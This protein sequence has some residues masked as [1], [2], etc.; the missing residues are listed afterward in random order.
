MVLMSFRARGNSIGRHDWGWLGGPYS[1]RRGGGLF[2]GTVLK[3]S[4]RHGPALFK[5]DN[6]WVFVSPRGFMRYSWSATGVGA[7]PFY[8]VDMALS[9]GVHGAL[10][11]KGALGAGSAV[12]RG[13]CV[14]PLGASA[15]R[16]GD[17]A[18]FHGEANHVVGGAGYCRWTC[19]PAL[20]VL[21]WSGLFGCRE[22]ARGCSAVRAA[23]L[24]I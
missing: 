17:G 23:M 9:A 24:V 5:P 8:C 2:F 12:L 14:I 3:F 21:P 18:P 11:S 1:A 15:P 10:T 4:I 19:L 7:G 16:G 13:I 20:L 6:G 22:G